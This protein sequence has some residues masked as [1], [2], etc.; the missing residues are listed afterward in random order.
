MPPLGIDVD[1]PRLLW[2]SGHGG[3]VDLGSCRWEGFVYLCVFQFG[4]DLYPT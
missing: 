1:L 3:W 4:Y 2:L